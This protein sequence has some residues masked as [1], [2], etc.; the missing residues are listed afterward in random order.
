MSDCAEVFF[1]NTENGTLVRVVG[2]ANFASA[3]PLREFARELP[4]TNLLELCIDLRECIGMDS[5]FM[6]VLSMIGLKYQKQRLKTEIVANANNLLLLKGLGVARLFEFVDAP[7]TTVGGA[8]AQAEACSSDRL[9]T[10]ETVL[11]AHKTLTEVDDSNAK[12]FS[13]VIELTETDVKNLRKERQD[14]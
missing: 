14:S 8:G 1:D 9:A 12:R 5:T 11:E 13:A 4:S 10:A 7:P 2:R 3:V 6:G